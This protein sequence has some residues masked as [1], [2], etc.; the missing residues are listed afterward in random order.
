VESLPL[1]EKVCSG[2]NGGNGGDAYEY[3]GLEKTQMSEHEQDIYP[4]AQSGGYGEE[5]MKKEALRPT[6]HER[7]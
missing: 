1:K 5:T 6:T 7:Q 3:P 2:N 4:D